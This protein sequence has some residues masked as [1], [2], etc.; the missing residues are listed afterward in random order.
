[1]RFM[2]A[3]GSVFVET[4]SQN[5]IHSLSSGAGRTR[6]ISAVTRILILGGYGVF[7]ARLARLLDGDARFEIIL[8]GRRAEKA[9]ALI[10]NLSGPATKRAAIL[11]IKNPAAALSEH[12]PD[13]VVHCAGPFQA[14]DYAVAEACIAHGVHYADLSDGRAFTEGF[15]ALDAKAKSAGVFALTAASTTSALSS[16]VA[17]SMADEFVHVDKVSVGVTPG[18]RAPRGSAV[19]AAILSYVGEPIPWRTRGRNEYTTGWGYVV[20]VRLP[21]LGARL[22][23]P[24]DAPDMAVMPKLFPEARDVEFRAG[25]ELSFLHWSLWG[26]AQLRRRRFIPNLSGAAAILQAASTLFLPFGSDRGGMFVELTG[27]DQ[28][29]APLRMR[30][31][32][33]AGSGDGPNIPAMAV[34]ALARKLAAGDPHATGA[35]ACARELTLDDFKN[36]FNAF[37]ITMH[38]ETF[39]G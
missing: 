23:S 15:S 22:F 8:A 25:L 29:G 17:L 39:D 33:Y 18:N 11:D 21:G 3:R 28:N 37:D 19:I 13:L 38:T 35:R 7:G 20:R 9:Q 32:L 12:K 2:F 34:A 36:E 16:A 14:Q 27:E 26:M 5:A 31:S 10:R 1:M 4:R 6:A 30:W 24:C